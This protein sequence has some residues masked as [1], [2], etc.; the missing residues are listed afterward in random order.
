MAH[1]FIIERNT[2]N[3]KAV[4]DFVNRTLTSMSVPDS[5]IAMMVLAVDEVCA[6]RMLHSP[7][8]VMPNDIELEIKN[9]QGKLTFV[10]RDT[11]DLYDINAHHEPDIKQL[12]ADK[13][14][15]GIGLLLV[16]KIMDT[17]EISR[18]EPYTV[19]LLHKSVNMA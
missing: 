13:R 6:N 3:L 7:T 4:R 8:R 5:D 9:D 14:K 18:S 15:G 1:K 19:L 17:I 2:Q 12:I 11:G 16:K 10:I